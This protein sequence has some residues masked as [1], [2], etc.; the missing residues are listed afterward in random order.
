MKHRLMKAGM[1]PLVAAI[2]LAAV[3][4]ALRAQDDAIDESPT[5]LAPKASIPFQPFPMVYPGTK[6]PMPRDA[7]LTLPDGRQVQAGQFYDELNRFEQSMA[8][9]GHSLRS[10]PE[11]VSVQADPPSE[12][13]M[14]IYN[15]DES[16]DAEPQSAL[17][18]AGE[19]A[20]TAYHYF[21]RS[22][23]LDRNWGSSK[24][25]VYLKGKVGFSAIVKAPTTSN[26]QDFG[27]TSTALRAYGN[28]EIGGTVLGYGITLA[29]ADAEFVA[30]AKPSSPLSAA[31]KLTVLGMTVYN[32]NEKSYTTWQKGDQWSYPARVGYPFYVP[33]YIGFITGEVGIQGEVGFRYDVI[34]ERVKLSSVIRPFVNVSA[35]GEAGYS[36]IVFGA[37]VGAQLTFLDYSLPVT[38]GLRPTYL[39]FLG[40]WALE[41]Y[42]WVSHDVHVLSGKVYAYAYAY[43]PKFGIP[44]WKKVTFTH[45][46]F[47]WNGFHENKTLLSK[48]QNFLL[49]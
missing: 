41:T 4:G 5:Y 9:Q 31:A 19:D 35:Y 23:I 37:G 26:P 29:R 44:P 12:E 48:T 18:P 11:S 3:P 14:Q 22:Q 33:I 42:I 13:E 36:L 20:T 40:K 21:D 39:W 25:N 16:V 1:L 2:T 6:Q 15:G 34:L 27:Q 43:V 45:T 32:L 30:P 17:P 28:G 8:A 38:V 47:K 46:F 10:V 49:N 7:L 24:W